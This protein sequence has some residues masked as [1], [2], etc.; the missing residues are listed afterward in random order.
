MSVRYVYVMKGLSKSYP[1]G[2]EVLKDIWLSFLPG[3]KIGIVGHNGAGKSTLLKIMAG[4]ITEFNGEAWPA[5]GIKVGYLEQEPELDENKTVHE[6]VMDG[7]AEKKA[8]I[9]RYNEIMADY[10]DD[11]ADEAAE[12]QD[13]IDAANA[14]DIDR[15]ADVAMDALRCPAGDSAVDKLS[16]GEKRRV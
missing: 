9:D 7:L 5:E 1:G 16:G 14:W 11:V 3:A 2:K 12:L 15:E 10:S 8:L 6:N 13:K 4:K